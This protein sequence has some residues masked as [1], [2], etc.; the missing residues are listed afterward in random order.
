M[1]SLDQQSPISSSDYCGLIYWSYLAGTNK[2]QLDEFSRSEW[3][4]PTVRILCLISKA[5]SVYPISRL[6]GCLDSAVV[7]QTSGL[8]DQPTTANLLRMQVISVKQDSDI[9]P[10]PMDLT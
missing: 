5:F 6:G 3:V 10:K 8:K 1:G 2:G 4:E 9:P 7:F